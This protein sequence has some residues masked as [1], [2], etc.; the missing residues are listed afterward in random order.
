MSVA[1]YPDSFLAAAVASIMASTNAI[2]MHS[3]GS[4]TPVNETDRDRTDHLN[5]YETN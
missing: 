2:D 3:G 1:P 4:P 5:M